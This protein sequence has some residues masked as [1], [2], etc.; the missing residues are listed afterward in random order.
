MHV[1]REDNNEMSEA[2]RTLMWTEQVEG[3]WELA[4]SPN[5]QKMTLGNSTLGPQYMAFTLSPHEL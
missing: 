4:H 2:L 3:R 5:N 1:S